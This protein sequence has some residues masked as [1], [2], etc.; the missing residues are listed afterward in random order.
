MALPLS[1]VA[2]SPDGKTLAVGGYREVLLW[3]LAAGKL[4]KRIGAGQIGNM[5]QAVLFS[6][7]GKSLAEPEG[8]R[9]PRAR[10][11]SSTSR[12]DRWP[13]TSMSPR[14]WCSRWT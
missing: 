9:T 7:D 8:I 1:A 4:A 11:S 14:A 3:D 2:F 5:V 13:W 10:S 6:K 12:A